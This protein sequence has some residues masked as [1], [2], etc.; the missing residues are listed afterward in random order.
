MVSMSSFPRRVSRGPES[1][2]GWYTLLR[3]NVRSGQPFQA[4]KIIAVIAIV[5]SSPCLLLGFAHRMH[6]P[7]KQFK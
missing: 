1:V 2:S 3:F 4:K 7:V 5:V 6:L